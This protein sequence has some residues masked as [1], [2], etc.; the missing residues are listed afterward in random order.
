MVYRYI[1]KEL[2]EEI[3]NEYYQNGQQK[4][5][6]LVDLVLFR[7]KFFDVNTE[8]FYNLSD[9]I[10]CDALK[11]YDG[12]QEFNSFLYSCLM[13]KFKTEMTKQN[14]VK[15]KSEKNTISWDEKISGSE[16]DNM[17]IGDTIATKQTVESELF[18]NKEEYY[19][20]RML[21]Y[22]SRLSNLQ[23][24][25]LR[26]TVAGYLPGEIRG[27]LHMTKKQYCDNYAAIHSYRNISVLL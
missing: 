24:E 22:L 17:T 14:R 2:G 4:I 20:T 9:E 19:S 3:A 18:E 15:R 1:D 6:K 27:E 16:S 7:L 13:N 11:R 10:F 21:A 5:R 8:D 23:K 25:I 26:L 12:I